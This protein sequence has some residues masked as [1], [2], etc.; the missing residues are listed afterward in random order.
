[1][2]LLSTLTESGSEIS[3]RLSS[4]QSNKVLLFAFITSCLS[5][6]VVNLAQFMVTSR[7]GALPMQVIGN[8]KTVFVSISS[9][10]LFQNVVTVQGVLGYATTLVGVMLFES[11]RRQTGVPNAELKQQ[12]RKPNSDLV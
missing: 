5:A 8:M 4:V 3:N 6:F 7:F 2:L 12:G 11:S 1:M 9:I 10:A